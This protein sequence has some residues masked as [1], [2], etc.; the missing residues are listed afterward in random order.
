M[1]INKEIDNKSEESQYPCVF[2]VLDA[3]EDSFLCQH[4]G[5]I[6][7]KHE[8]FGGSDCEGYLPD[9]SGEGLTIEAIHE[10]ANIFPSMTEEE[11]EGLKADIQVNGQLEP[12]ILYDWRILDGKHRN[13]ACLELGIQPIY[14]FRHIDDPIKYVVSQNLHRRHLNESQRAMVGA[15]L[16]N[17]RVGNP[18]FANSENLP[19]NISQMEAAEMLNTSDRSIR[20]AKQVIQHGTPELVK[21]VDEGKIAVSLAEKITELSQEKQSQFV[22]AVKEGKKPS[23][24]YRE[25][26]RTEI[27]EQPIPDN[28]YRVIYA[29]PPWQYNDSGIINDDNYGRAERHYSTMP[30]QDI[31]NL[32]VKIQQ[33]TLPD[34]VL[35]IWATSPM[36]EDVFAVIKAWGFQYK[37][38]FVW[39]KVK[40]N[41]GH[42]NSVRHEFLLICTRGSCLPDSKE[43]IDSVQSIEKTLVH[44]EKPEEFR[45]IIDKLYPDGKR[46]ELFARQQVEGWAT[47][48]NQNIRS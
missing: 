9:L 17:M 29:D 42:Y 46:I 13:R 10:A 38:S 16:A 45:C 32:G 39:D 40:H 3:Y 11:Y 47:W 33:L 43:L 4:S 48:G 19:N 35:F 5:K 20:D 14:A 12:I 21:A 36:L 1:I 25:I 8:G 34:A 44:S 24:A 27:T 2:L 15:R 31:C 26:K 28:K 18:D 7:V 23:Q 22:E 30:L 41:Y 37:T 6:C